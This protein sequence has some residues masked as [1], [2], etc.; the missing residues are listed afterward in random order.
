MS[1]MT[2]LTHWG[3]LAFDFQI[4]PTKEKAYEE[5]QNFHFHPADSTIL[6]NVFSLKVVYSS[7]SYILKWKYRIATI[8]AFWDMEDNIKTIWFV[9]LEKVLAYRWFL[10]STAFLSKH[11]MLRLRKVAEKILSNPEYNQNLAEH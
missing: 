10:Y 6:K 11:E 5:K 3:Q 4:T 1:I 9:D 8:R 2:S 7:R